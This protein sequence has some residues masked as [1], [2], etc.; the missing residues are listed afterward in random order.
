M[1]IAILSYSH[2]GNNEALA[3]RVAQELAIEHI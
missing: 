1:N 2:T 3:K